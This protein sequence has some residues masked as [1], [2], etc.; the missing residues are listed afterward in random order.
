[1]GLVEGPPT[2]VWG[3][4]METSSAFLA[5]QRPWRELVNIRSFSVP[6]G[7]LDYGNRLR[8]NLSY[9]GVNY[10]LSLLAI[11]VALLAFRPTA[12]GMLGVIA[13]IWVYVFVVRASEMQIGRYVLNLKLQAIIMFFSSIVVIF[14]L[15][16]VGAMLGSGMVC[17][18]ALICVHAGL[19]T[20]EQDIMAE[21]AEGSGT[22][23]KGL[24]SFVESNISKDSLDKM[25]IDSLKA[26]FKLPD[27]A[28]TRRL[29]RGMDSIV[30]KVEG[31][32]SI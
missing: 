12:L 23:F 1:M 2:G 6:N 24:T 14:Y 18:A 7:Y 15:T 11:A 13:A 8:K 26:T 20:P 5:K 17:G 28:F 22:L 19:R 29:E 10:L 31:G 3:A 4:A 30:A 25:S 32:M 16:N 27:N 21:N 9:F